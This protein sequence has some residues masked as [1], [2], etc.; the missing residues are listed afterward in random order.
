LFLKAINLSLRHSCRIAPSQMRIVPLQISQNTP[1]HD[2]ELHVEVTMVSEGMSEVVTILIPINNRSL[3]K[4]Y[5]IK[6]TYFYGQSMPTAFIAIP[7]SLHVEQ[8]HPIFLA[9]RGCLSC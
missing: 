8:A 7:P 2:H 5:T 4:A 9:L 3:E 1:F 6:A